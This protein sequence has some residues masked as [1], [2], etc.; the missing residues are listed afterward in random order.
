MA[1]KKIKLKT[2]KEALEA[3]K[4]RLLKNEKHDLAS[5]VAEKERRRVIDQFEEDLESWIKINTIV[6]KDACEIVDRK[7]NKYMKKHDLKNGISLIAGPSHGG[8]EV[9][10]AA[11]EAG[12]PRWYI[13]RYV[14]GITHGIF[15]TEG[16]SV[17]I[18]H[19][20]G[21]KMNSE[22]PRSLLALPVHIHKMY[23][24]NKY[25]EV[26]KLVEEIIKRTG[27]K[28]SVRRKGASKQCQSLE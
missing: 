3:I 28:K 22:D 20:D 17:D 2:Q 1:I 23:E 24:S 18:H 11:K 5:K 15:L 10:V 26:D 4:D 16:D 27:K 21:N 13:H 9:G 8:Y 19:I 12:V 6:D 25:P 14:F 7:A